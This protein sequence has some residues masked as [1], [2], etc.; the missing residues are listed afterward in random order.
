MTEL[1]GHGDER[2]GLS[3]TI[4]YIILPHPGICFLV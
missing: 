2:M 1:D 3:K 4:S